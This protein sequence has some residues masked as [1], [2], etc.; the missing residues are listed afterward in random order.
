MKRTTGNK[1][2]TTHK[3]MRNGYQHTKE[4]ELKVP[5]KIINQSIITPIQTENFKQVS[6]KPTNQ[7]S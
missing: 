2:H 1:T 3:A 4:A 6:Y 7:T 5:N